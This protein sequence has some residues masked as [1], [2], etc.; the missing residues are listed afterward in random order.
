[1]TETELVLY[2]LVSVAVMVAL[3]LGVILFYY[4]SQRKIQA[5]RLRAESLKTQYQKELLQQTIRTQEEERDRIA[6]ELHDDIGS[7][8]NI[9]H[10]NLHL[11]RTE[12]QKGQ[13]IEEMLVDMQTA[14]KSSIDSSRQISHQLMPSTL[15]KFGLP[16]AIEDLQQL[17]NQSPRP[18]L[19][20]KGADHCE[21][22]DDQAQLHL[23]RIVQELVQNAIKHANADNLYLSFAREEGGLLLAYEDDGVGLPKDLDLS[24]G[25]GMSNLQTRIQMLE[26]EW[27][28]DRA[29]SSGT[30]MKLQ[31]PI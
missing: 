22:L 15:R 20:V 14:L 12:N 9:I 5:E 1:M 28:I 10:L 27:A 17:V 19:T 21:A 29:R 18:Q 30:A 8:L 23:F 24:S 3:A 11:L 25:L 6:R 7:K 13:D 4:I 26:G 31:I 2:I 16:A